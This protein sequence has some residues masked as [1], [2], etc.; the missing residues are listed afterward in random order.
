MF[1][2][3]Q[4]YFLKNAL[5]MK[6]KPIGSEFSRVQ[7]ELLLKKRFVVF[8]PLGYCFEETTRFVVCKASSVASHQTR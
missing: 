3:N 8:K 6:L 4:D 1:P 2:R 5:G 7:I